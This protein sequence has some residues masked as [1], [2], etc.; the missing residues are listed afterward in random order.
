MQLQVRAVGTVLQIFK[1]TRCPIDG[2][3]QFVVGTLSIDEVETLKRKIDE[4][5]PAVRSA[6]A[7]ANARLCIELREKAISLRKNLAEV[8]AELSMFTN[9]PMPAIV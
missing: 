2:I 1:E 4:A 8:E 9:L 6:V 7:D 5:I 3:D